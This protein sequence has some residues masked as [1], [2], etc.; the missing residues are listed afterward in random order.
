MTRTTLLAACLLGTVASA[1]G[2]P[3]RLGYQGR[4]FNTDGT[5]ATGSVTLA[6]SLFP[7][8]TSGAAVWGPESHQLVLTDG[9]Y[10]VYLGD[11]TPSGCMG[12]SCT[13]IPES[14]FTGADLYLELSVNGTAL[15]PRQRVASVA[16]AVTARNVA[17]GSVSATTISVGGSPVIDAMGK[18]VGA[19]AYSA[20]PG[21]EIS[22][23]G[24]IGLKSGC[25]AGQVLRFDGSGWTCSSIVVDGGLVTTVSVGAGLAGDGSPTDPLRST[26][27][28]GSGLTLSP[29]NV[30][31]LPSTCTAGQSL[32]YS[33]SSWVCS[34]VSASDAGGF[35]GL[36][37][38]AGL[39]GNGTAANP[40]RLAGSAGATSTT[41]V[42]ANGPRPVQP[43]AMA[44]ASATFP[45]GTNAW[46]GFG[47]RAPAVVKVGGT[48]RMVFVGET[49]ATVTDLGTATS[50]DG[51]TWTRTMTPV[52]TRGAAGQFDAARMDTPC[53]LHDGTTYHLYYAGLNAASGGA[54]RLGKATSTDGL[55]WTKVPGAA[56]LNAVLGLGAAGTFD[57]AHVW[58]CS[59][60]KDGN[61]WTLWYAGY[62][63]TNWRIGR[64]T[65]T[66]GL[67]WTRDAANPV[68]NTPVV[69]HYDFNPAAAPA[70]RIW[71]PSVARIGA[72]YYMLYAGSPNPATG[73]Y[74]LIGLA[75]S[76]D[77][78][79]WSKS[80]YPLIMN[81]P[82]IPSVQPGSWVVDG[83][84]ILF[85][86]TQGNGTFNVINTWVM[87]HQ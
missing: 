20:G 85:F 37:V 33:G 6:F 1:Q 76:R 48:F 55:T 54:W 50:A 27:T 47:V 36:T 23:A 21:I 22:T 59:V 42:Y 82:G 31:S 65:S 5:A 39:L 40:L 53:L 78:R 12:T 58:S 38:G 80:P 62:D 61:T 26:L 24:T 35:A 81:E 86:G 3:S 79:V 64:A 87:D 2:V 28:V 30:L 19:A 83:S 14:V 7:D 17:G 46:D 56:G 60:M 75:T 67:A 70:S 57:D 84:R 52:L 32:V 73:T 69:S 4:L 15:T 10:A 63:G 66:D 8:A 74:T 71:S 43:F 29:S 77:G 25:A 16:Y 44:Q 9:W 49:S 45:R 51:V 34:T 11:R 68:L 41:G 13:G 72:T 18:L